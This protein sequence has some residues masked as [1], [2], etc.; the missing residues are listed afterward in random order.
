MDC[1]ASGMMDRI[2]YVGKRAALTKFCSLGLGNK[3][4]D[5]ADCCLFLRELTSVLA[6]IFNQGVLL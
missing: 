4:N 2:N 1:N 5:D 3:K 6:Y